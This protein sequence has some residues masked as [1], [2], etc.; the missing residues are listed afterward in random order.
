M[1]ELDAIRERASKGC[2]AHDN[3]LRADAAR[4]IGAV[5]AV[6]KLHKPRESPPLSF[7]E[8]IQGKK[9]CDQC[10]QPYPCP[11]VVALGEALG[12]AA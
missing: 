5:D 9:L 10:L 8:I 11:T 1:T 3:C 12:G 4:L 6:E 7:R 2:P